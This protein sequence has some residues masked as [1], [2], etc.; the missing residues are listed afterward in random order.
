MHM[1]SLENKCFAKCPIHPRC[2]LREGSAPNLSC[3]TSSLRN[4]C[5]GFTRVCSNVVPTH[6]SLLVKVAARWQGRCHLSS[7]SKIHRL[8]TTP[9]NTIFSWAGQPVRILEHAFMCGQ[10]ATLIYEPGLHFDHRCLPGFDSTLSLLYKW[11]MTAM[12]Y[13]W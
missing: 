2:G 10:L 3:P 7:Y 5:Q 8:A 13:C 11:A 6:T 9:W 1:Q 4:I 12:L